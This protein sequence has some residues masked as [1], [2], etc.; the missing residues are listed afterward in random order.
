MSLRAARVATAVLLSATVALLV[1][2]MFVLINRRHKAA[3]KMRNGCGDE[4]RDGDMAPPW[5]V[6]LY[7][8]KP[9]IV[10]SEVARCLTVSNVIG[11]GWSG[12]VYRTHIPANGNFPFCFWLISFF[13][14]LKFLYTSIYISTQ[15]PTQ[16]IT[17]RKEK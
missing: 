13:P 3:I 12:P 5:E 14:F 6:T 7:Q 10:I 4:E 1:V 11:Q 17:K 16:R 2:T 15:L 8:K 9:D